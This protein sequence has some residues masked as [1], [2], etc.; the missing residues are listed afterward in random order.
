MWNDGQLTILLNIIREAGSEILS[1]YSDKTISRI[2][3]KDDDS[4][5]TEA[6]R[7]ANGIIVRELKKLPLNFP[8]LSEESE[9]PSYSERQSWADYWLIDPLDGTKEFIKENGEFTVNIAHIRNGIPEMGAVHVPVSGVTYLGKKGLGAW[10]INQDDFTEE[11]H[12]RKIDTSS[13]P[14]K[15]LASRSHRNDL[16]D[17]LIQD[18]SVKV[19]DLEVIAMGSSLKICLLAEGKADLYPRLT[20]TC[21]WDTAAAHAVLAGSGGEI[22][23]VNFRALKYNQKSSLVNPNFFA[24]ADPNFDWDKLL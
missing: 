10:R 8:I 14:L 21:E 13:R 1:V 16:L 11:I 5:I 9:K 15:V 17:N 7:L 3:Y 20:P 18:I 19:G 6:D 4:P 2:S 22:F 12:S 24:V 23:D